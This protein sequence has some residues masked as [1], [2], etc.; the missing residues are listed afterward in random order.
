MCQAAL[1]A[2]PQTTQ[3]CLQNTITTA[4]PGVSTAVFVTPTGFD[5]LIVNKT[6][7]GSAIAAL[8][9]IPWPRSTASPELELVV[10]H[11]A[12]VTTSASMTVSRWPTS[13]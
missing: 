1:A 7:S 5:A 4:P 10:Y 11:P 2:Y 8:G 3:D 13:A 12:T 6:V 9:V